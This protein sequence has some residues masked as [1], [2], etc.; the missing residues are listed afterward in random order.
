MKLNKLFLGLLG[1]TAMVMSSC[2][3]KDDYQWATASGEQVYFSK[4]LP[5]TQE[6]SFD[7]S[8]F[9]IPV[10]R[11]NTSSSITVPISIESDDN[12]FS[13]PSSISFAAGEATTN[14]TIS[15]D[16]DS[17][18][19][20]VYKNAKVTIGK[21]YSTPYGNETYSFKGG[22]ASP[23]HAE[24]AEPGRIPYHGSV[25]RSGKGCWGIT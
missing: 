25:P 18:E 23:Y 8:S 12:F 1:L 11:V 6:I 13:A 22:I 20:D 16:P 14:L 5:A 21:E 19:Y 7:A 15:Y 17:L 4:D 2:S 24:H 10:S 9:T 3:D